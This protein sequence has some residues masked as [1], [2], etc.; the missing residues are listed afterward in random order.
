MSR[1]AQIKDTKP[2]IEVMKQM[3]SEGNHK[4]IH[5]NIYTVYL[6]YGA[7][8]YVAYDDANVPV[9]INATRFNT[10]DLAPWEPVMNCYSFYTI[11][12]RR[13]QGLATM[14]FRYTEAI[15]RAAGCRS[16]RSL[17]QTWDG[18]YTHLSFGHDVW[19]MNEKKELLISGH[20][21]TAI[22][23][24][25]PSIRKYVLDGAKPMTREAAVEL[26]KQS[27]ICAA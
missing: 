22:P 4:V 26:A 14:L 16:V 3:R 19:G 24:V 18:L 12:S 13:R 9:S 1:I 17:A 2:L 8:I 23:G 20:L 27:W 6:F 11:P 10:R 7:S 15:A 25:P 21:G 5:G